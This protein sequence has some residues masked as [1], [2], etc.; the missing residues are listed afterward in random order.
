MNFVCH[1]GRIQSMNDSQPHSIPS[2]S[3]KGCFLKAISFVDNPYVDLDY[4][5]TQMQ[6]IYISDLVQMEIIR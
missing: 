5:I 1:S 4:T 6:Q 2:Y 3:V